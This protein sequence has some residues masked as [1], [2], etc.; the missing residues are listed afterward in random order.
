MSRDRW[1]FGGTNDAEENQIRPAPWPDVEPVRIRRKILAG[2]MLAL[3]VAVFIY[4]SQ[5]GSLD[6]VLE[7]DLLDKVD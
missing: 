6:R 4:V 3:V 1:G 2:A 5:T 7:K